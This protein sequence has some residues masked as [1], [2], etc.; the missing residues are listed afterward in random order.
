MGEAPATQL[1]SADSG[2]GANGLPQSPLSAKSPK[3][4]EGLGSCARMEAKVRA[5]A[6][7]LA[8]IKARPHHTPVSLLLPP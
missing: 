5:L 8:Q 2:H 6:G 1:V 7:K 4:A 3:L